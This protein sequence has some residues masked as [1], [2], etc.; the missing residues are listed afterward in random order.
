[1]RNPPSASKA[2]PKCSAL[3]A[4]RSSRQI[5]MMSK[6]SIMPPCTIDAAGG[7][8]VGL[9]AGGRDGSFMAG[10]YLPS[11]LFH[12]TRRP[13]SSRCRPFEVSWLKDGSNRAT[14]AGL[15]TDTCWHAA[16]VAQRRFDPERCQHE[17]AID[18]LGHH[19]LVD[20]EAPGGTRARDEAR[21]LGDGEPLAL[22]AAEAGRRQ[23]GRARGAGAHAEPHDAAPPGAIGW[24]HSGQE[25]RSRG[26]VEDD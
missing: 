20:V 21:R 10:T 3:S 8:R 16:N 11:G 4:G 25:R 5:T 15:G 2:M 24:W 26:V 7:L 6:T 13:R 23:Q 17:H 1:M 14:R 22:P 19:A 12:R 9:S 18:D